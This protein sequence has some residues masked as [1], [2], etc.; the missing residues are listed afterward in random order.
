MEQGGCWATLVDFMAT[1]PILAWRLNALR[2]AHNGGVFR[3]RKLYV[4]DVPICDE[5]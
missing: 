3:I 2:K 1:H 4:K 5:S